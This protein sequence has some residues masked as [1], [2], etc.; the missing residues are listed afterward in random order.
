MSYVCACNCIKN[1]LLN[2]INLINSVASTVHEK[3]VVEERRA[4]SI[5]RAEEISE[6]IVKFALALL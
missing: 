3:M 2:K 4:L 1:I 5:S 6:G